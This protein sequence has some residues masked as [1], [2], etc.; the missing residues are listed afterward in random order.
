MRA[1]IAGMEAEEMLKAIDL[2]AANQ[3]PTRPWVRLRTLQ[4]GT[5]GLGPFV[6]WFNDYYQ[7]R[8][9]NHHLVISN[10]DQSAR[11]DWR[12]FQRIKNE[13]WGPEV[14]AVELYPAE[15]RL[16]DPSNAFFLYRHPNAAKLGIKRGRQIATPDIAIA[17]QRSFEPS[18]GEPNATEED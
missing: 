13:I 7:V 4:P 12:E 2:N 14:E 10:N 1:T 6:D 16:V 17:P 9:R 5:D 11:H 15:S 3:P 8:D 18:P